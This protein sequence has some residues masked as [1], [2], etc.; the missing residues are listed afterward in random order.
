MKNGLTYTAY[1]PRNI[2]LY[3]KLVGGFNMMDW[4]MNEVK[5]Q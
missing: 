5:S 1:T 3:F 2:L 4:P